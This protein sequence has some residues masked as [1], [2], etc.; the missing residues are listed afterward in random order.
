MLLSYHIN[1][2]LQT[3]VTD[4]LIMIEISHFVRNDIQ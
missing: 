2:H 4:K 3:L 1:S